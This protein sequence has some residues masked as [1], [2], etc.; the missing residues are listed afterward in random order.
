MLLKVDLDG[1][2]LVPSPHPML[3][4]GFVVHRSIHM[5]RAD[6][7]CVMHTH[8]SAGMAV[9]LKEAGLRHDDFYGAM[10]Y[11]RVAYHDFEGITIHA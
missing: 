5:A 6:A 9:A 2:K 7:H 4:A 1:N 11:G 8:T 3:M 10:L